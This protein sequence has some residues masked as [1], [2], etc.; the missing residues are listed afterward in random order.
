MSELPSSIVDW[1]HK[2]QDWLQE[3]AQILLTAGSVSDDQISTLVTRLKTPGGQNT[4][5]H[6]SFAGAAPQSPAD[7]E[8]R[9]A[10]I[11]D[12]HGIENLT[13]Q[14]TLDFRKGNLCVIYG[15]NASGKSGYVRLLKSACGKPN[16]G[17]L[18]PNVFEAEP[19]KRQ[20]QITY[21]LGDTERSVTWVPD[22]TPVDDLRA[23]DVFDSSASLAYLTT[24]TAASYTPPAVALFENLA[25][26]C[27][28]VKQRLQE[29]QDRLVSKLPALPSMFLATPAG[30]QYQKIRAG[31]TNEEVERLVTWQASDDEALAKLNQRLRVTDP[32]ASATRKRKTLA[33]VVALKDLLKQAS[34]A[35]SDSQ[36]KNIRR[37]REDALGKRRVAS[38]S[39]KVDSAQL[40]GIGTDT[41]RALWQAARKYS[42]TAYPGRDYPV[43]DEGARCVLC[44][45]KLQPNAQERLRDFDAFVQGRLES[46]AAAAEKIYQETLD[47]L[48][49]PLTEED[50]ATRCQAADLTDSALLKQLNALWA[51][52]RSARAALMHSETEK[53]ASPI[54]WPTK[55]I[56]ELEKCTDK[57]HDEI[58]QLEKDAEGFDRDK[59]ATEKLNLEAREWVSQQADAIRAEITRLQQLDEYETWKSCANSQSISRQAG[60]ISS[61][62]VTQAFVDRFNRELSSLGAFRIKVEL[63]RSRTEKGKPLHKLQLKGAQSGQDLLNEVLSDGERRIVGLAAFLADVVDKPGIAPFVFDDPISSLDQEYEWKVVTRLVELAKTRQVIVFTHRLSLYGALEEAARKVEGAWKSQ[64]LE[65][66]CLQSFSGTAG[67]LI[68]QPFW[69]ANTKKANNILLTR[70][71]RAKKTGEESGPQPYEE[72]AQGICSDFR[73]LLERTIESDLLN[74]IVKRHRRSVM[75]QGKLERLSLISPNDC[76]FF[77]TL[78]TKYSSYEHSQSTEMPVQIP[79]ADELQKDIQALKTWREEFKNACCK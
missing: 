68:D 3:A 64:H 21:R 40:D 43:I 8:L 61:Q 1:L 36:V 59:T 4:T 22:S 55:A 23:V 74:E 72:L 70:L 35:F 32:T 63:Q 7:Q 37:L 29:E 17:P 66:L 79:E 5:N 20:C 24:E 67:H 14:T 57:L 56:E 45:Q 52:I 13:S 38:E 49:A 15:H 78:M 75:T 11:G 48:P 42:Q 30:A 33:Q 31:L 44:Q 65:Q 71:D 50:V 39:A 47:A 62:L 26:V 27:D 12:I 18:K 69:S 19:A 46:E 10:S 77:D 53:Q 41:W 34:N 2:Q 25:A 28:R 51:S 16:T 60:K 58:K 6:R 73:K 9:L 76:Q 54:G